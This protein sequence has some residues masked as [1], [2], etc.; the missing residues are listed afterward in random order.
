MLNV[1]FL[2]SIATHLLPFK[3]TVM[4]GGEKGVTERKLK[5]TTVSFE[6]I[7]FEIGEQ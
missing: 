4:V 1:E 7:I 5:M 3:C 2:K 6:F